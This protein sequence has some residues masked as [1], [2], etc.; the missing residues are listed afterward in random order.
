MT[1]S[2]IYIC[3]SLLY[4]I[5]CIYVAHILDLSLYFIHIYICICMYI[6]IY[7]YMF[8]LGTLRTRAHVR[9]PGASPG[10]PRGGS[11]AGPWSAR[12]PEPPTDP[13]AQGPPRTWEPRAT[14]PGVKP[15]PATHHNAPPGDPPLDLIAICKL[16]G[17]Y[18]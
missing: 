15:T 13:G 5:I 9:G 2:L 3:I 17:K 18:I 1:D 12:G 6:Y 8:R 14:K 7:V 10:G 11:P 16:L 4:I